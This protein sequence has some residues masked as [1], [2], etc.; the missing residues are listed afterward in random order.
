MFNLEE[1]KQSIMKLIDSRDNDEI[2]IPVYVRLYN[3]RYLLHELDQIKIF[4]PAAFKVGFGSS[5]GM[6]I[7]NSFPNQLL[8]SYDETQ[9]FMDV[10]E[11]TGVSV[12]YILFE[13]NDKNDGSTTVDSQIIFYAEKIREY[14]E[15]QCE[16]YKRQLIQSQ[17]EESN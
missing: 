5:S 4:N 11:D 1:N 16:E 7:K 14:L 13:S 3:N 17:M 10:D 2:I 12:R 9:V 6:F 8:L 15:K